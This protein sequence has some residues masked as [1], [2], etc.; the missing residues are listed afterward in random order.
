[1]AQALGFNNPK[2]LARVDY[3]YMEALKN[4][5]KLEQKVISMSRKTQ[6]TRYQYIAN[7]SA[8]QLNTAMNYEGVE[9]LSHLALH[10]LV[11]PKHGRESIRSRIK[12]LNLDVKLKLHK[13]VFGVSSTPQFWPTK[14]YEKRL[15]KKGMICI[16]CRFVATKPQQIEL[17]H[18]TDRDY[19]PKDERKI[20]YYRERELTEICANCHSL[21]HRTGEH[22]EKI[23]GK[24]RS[25]P[26]LNLK[27]QNPADLFSPSCPEIHTLQ[28]NYFL[29]WNLRDPSQYKCDIC[30]AK[31]WGP[32]NQVLSLELHHKDG[33]RQ[34]SL[35]SNLQLLCPNCHRSFFGEKN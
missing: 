13:G 21:K 22:L 17:H 20:E 25:T 9:T 27:Y 7:L 14:A 35:I 6:K 3:E 1:L 12:S 33:H 11:S 15:G 34:N 2:G 30:G 23:C 26:P 10:F 19:G 8:E 18:P 28:K 29:K 16:V 31:N 24:W 5:D 32:E 4:R